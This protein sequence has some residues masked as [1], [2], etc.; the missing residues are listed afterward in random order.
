MTTNNL[1]TYDV[2]ATSNKPR[3]L[4]INGFIFMKER[5]PDDFEVCLI[6]E[7]DGHLSAGCWDTGTYS[8]EDG[9]PGAFRQSRGGVIDAEYVLAWL[10]IEEASIDVTQ[11][12]WK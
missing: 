6:I 2:S 3:D 11:L 9:K 1:T 5:L 8:T 7:N 4:T 10:P 12:Q